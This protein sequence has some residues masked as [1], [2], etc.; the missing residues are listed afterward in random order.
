VQQKASPGIDL[1]ESLYLDL[2]RTLAALTVVLDHLGLVFP[3]ASLPVGRWG[4]QAVLVFFVLSGY[5][6]SRSASRERNAGS[7]IV[8]RLAR[9]WPVLVPALVLTVACDAVGLSRGDPAAYGLVPHDY[10]VV[11]IGATLAFLAESW[12]SIQP[13]SNLAVWSLCAEFWYYAVFAAW[14]FTPP[15]RLRTVLVGA[16]VLLAGHKAILLTPIWFMGVALDRWRTG[17]SIGLASSVA[18][19]FLGALVFASVTLAGAYASVIG[20]LHA[21]ASPFIYR[22]LG[23]ARAFPRVSIGLVARTSRSSAPARRTQGR[24]LSTDR[25][26]RHTRALVRRRELRRLSLPYAVA[27]ALGLA[28]AR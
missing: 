16:A 24:L 7:F 1:R 2:L 13:F 8:A 4:H 27:R 15:G 22:Q 17:R 9:L 10:P 19:F 25:A 21:W 23:Q 5:V 14:F 11:R 26:H 28:P 6:I 12:V 18:L 3:Q 20:T